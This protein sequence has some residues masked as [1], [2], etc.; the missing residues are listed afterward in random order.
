MP[1]IHQVAAVADW[2]HCEVGLHVSMYIANPYV[3]RVALHAGGH[4]ATYNGCFF[5][6]G[7]KNIQ[8]IKFKYEGF[9]APSKNSSFIS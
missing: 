2:V 4:C 1:F 5:F 9:G 6:K 8:Q 3:C 7:Y